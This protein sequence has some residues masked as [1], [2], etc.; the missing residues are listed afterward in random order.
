MNIFPKCLKT[1]KNYIPAHPSLRVSLTEI[2][3]KKVRFYG[4]GDIIICNKQLNMLCGPG[5]FISFEL[6]KMCLTYV[7]Y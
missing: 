6:K 7:I 2:L 4:M 1:N 5:Q 3:F